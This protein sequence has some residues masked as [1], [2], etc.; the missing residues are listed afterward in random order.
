MAKIFQYIGDIFD[1]VF[2][3]ADHYFT[4]LKLGIV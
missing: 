3:F 1:L 4:F 2:Y